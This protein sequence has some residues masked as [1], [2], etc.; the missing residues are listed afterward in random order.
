MA[1]EL[2]MTL[3]ELVHKEG[4]RALT[5]ALMEAEVKQVGAGRYACAPKR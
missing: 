1:D 2:S 3:D 4:V 5:Q